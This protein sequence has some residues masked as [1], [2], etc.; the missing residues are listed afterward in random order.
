M[1]PE[2]VKKRDEMIRIEL[3]KI[4][5]QSPNTVPVYIII[6]EKDQQKIPD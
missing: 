5:K 3:E 4:S 2:E 6:N 1:I